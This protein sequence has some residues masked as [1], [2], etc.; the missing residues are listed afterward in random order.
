MNDPLYIAIDQGGHATRAVAFD[1]EGRQAGAAVVTVTTQRNALGHV[2]RVSEHAIQLHEGMLERHTGD[3]V[4]ATFDGPARGIRCALRICD[5]ARRGGV[6]VRCGLHA[7]EVIRRPEG[8]AGV[9]VHI[10][11]Q[12]LVADARRIER[13]EAGT[14][15]VLR[16][17]DPGAGE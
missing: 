1:R 17:A 12:D 4:L 9:A 13:A 2:E 16:D 3:G 7:G 14:G 5:E 10:G 8:L 11:H 6:E 15:P